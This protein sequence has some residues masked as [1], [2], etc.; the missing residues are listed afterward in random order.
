MNQTRKPSRSHSPDLPTANPAAAGQ[1]NVKNV[2]TIDLDRARQ[3]I[4]NVLKE[5]LASEVVPPE[6]LSFRMK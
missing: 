2:G 3:T 4:A 5:E 6:V 1:T